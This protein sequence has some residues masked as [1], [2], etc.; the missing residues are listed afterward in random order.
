MQEIKKDAKDIGITTDGDSG[1]KQNTS[2]TFRWN[3]YKT[4]LNW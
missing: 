4:G 1:V 2:K 3:G